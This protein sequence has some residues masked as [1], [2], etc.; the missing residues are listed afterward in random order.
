MHI[1][2]LTIFW[3]SVAWLAYIYVGYPAVLW[4]LARVRPERHEIASA[5]FFPRIS[6]LISARNE[7]ND[8]GW[9]VKETL[10]W[11]YPSD[12]LQVLVASDASDDGTDRV[13]EA[14]RDPRFQFVRMEKRGGKNVALERLANLATGDLLF[15]SDAN[16]HITS[17][18]VHNIVRHFAD[19]SVGCV[20]GVERSILAQQ[21][22]AIAAGG[23]AYL[24]YEA[25]LNTLESHLG[26]VLVCDGSIFCTRR[27]L[28]D[29]LDSELANDLEQPIKIGAR[30]YKVLYEPQAFS[31]ER[32][33]SSV[34]QEFTRRRRI[35]G[36]G[37]LGMWRLRLELRGLRVWQFFSR[38]LLRWLTIIPLV[39]ALFASLA[40]SQSPPFA[41]V[42]IAQIVFYLI[43]LMGW[44]STVAGRNVAKIISIP[45]YYVLVNVA[46]FVGILDTLLGRRYGIWDVATLS[47][48]HGTRPNA[49]ASHA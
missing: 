27:E 31:L 41:I 39:A 14:V 49:E 25:R 18:S 44:A 4:V 8:I 46:A 26:S 24:G 21:Q 33:T 5:N 22:E 20:T 47:R 45:F 19:P 34:R 32:A 11:A 30:G 37:I 15:F 35:C 29:S 1:V 10:A 6:V 7:E 2:L 12:C 40:L 3:L 28:F 38:K 17:D 23:G 43:A 16:S 13:L 42:A 48:G 36:Q 9:K